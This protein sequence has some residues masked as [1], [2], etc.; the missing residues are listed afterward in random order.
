MEVGKFEEAHVLYDKFIENAKNQFGVSHPSVAK[1]LYNKAEA[2]IRQGRY[3]EALECNQISLEIYSL[4][5][6][7]EHNL[8]LS[9]LFISM[10]TI[11]SELEQGDNENAFKYA[12]L[13][14]KINSKLFGESH[15]LTILSHL[16]VMRT[17]DKMKAGEEI[18][19]LFSRVK[20]FLFLENNRDLKAQFY[21]RISDAFLYLANVKNKEQN[22]KKALSYIEKAIDIARLLFDKE[23]CIKH[24]RDLTSYLNNKGV[25]LNELEKYNLAEEYLNESL[26]KLKDFFKDYKYPFILNCYLNIGNVYLNRN[27]VDAHLREALK[28]FRKELKTRMKLYENSEHRSLV[29]TYKSIGKAFYFL[30]EL[31]E[32]WHY[33][34]RARKIEVQ[35]SLKTDESSENLFQSIQK[36]LKVGNPSLHWSFTLTR[37]KRAANKKIIEYME[38]TVKN[39]M[40]K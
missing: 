27:C 2:F 36:E 25:I 8:D 7:N 17:Y 20:E 28:Y 18:I 29:E 6:N 38:R 9:L 26:K 19:D 11:Y 16:A 37:L 12:D 10:A 14:L 3:K 34:Q 30:G 13:S 1:G 22:L 31:D 40:R 39:D 35:F 4:E 23:P 33:I 24:L 32:A 5:T 21:S 15:R